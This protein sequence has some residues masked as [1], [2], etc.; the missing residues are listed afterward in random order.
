MRGARLSAECLTNVSRD[1]A[2][3]EVI[4]CAERT[5]RS[6]ANASICSGLSALRVASAVPKFAG[7]ERRFDVA[8]LLIL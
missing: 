3:T 4:A 5:E 2:A 6:N 7:R 1:P 8:G